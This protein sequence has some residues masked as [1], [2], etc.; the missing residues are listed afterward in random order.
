[1]LEPKKYEQWVKA[2]SENSQFKG[3]WEEG[4]IVYFIDPGMGGTKAILEKF[5]PYNCIL[6]K[7]I[8]MVAKDGSEDTESETAKQWIGTIEKYIFTEESGKTILTVEMTTD[9]AFKGMFETCWPKA[10]ENIK[11]LVEGA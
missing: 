5:D 3:S 11:L 6:A 2:F 1:M 8:A 4:A 9:V 7:H 10:L